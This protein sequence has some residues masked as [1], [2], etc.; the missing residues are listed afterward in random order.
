MEAINIRNNVPLK[1]LRQ[2]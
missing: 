2:I 1:T